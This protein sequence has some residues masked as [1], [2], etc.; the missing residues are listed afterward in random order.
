VT[1]PAC[2]SPEESRNGLREKASTASA[3]KPC[4]HARRAPSICT[5]RSAPA[6]SPSATT[7]S[8]VSAHCGL[9]KSA[10]ATGGLPRGSHSGA[11]VVQSSVKSSRTDSTVV[12]T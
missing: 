9:R 2:R 6:A 1:R 10:P 12:D 3:T 7:R 8:S 11:D 5:P 4:D